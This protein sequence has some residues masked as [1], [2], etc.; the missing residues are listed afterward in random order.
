MQTGCGDEVRL[1]G[2]AGFRG[3]PGWTA[4]RTAP[5]ELLMQE[6]PPLLA[7]LAERVGAPAFQFN[8]Y[9]SDSE[10][11]ME[12]DPSGRVEL[13]GY[14]GYEPARYWNGDP[15]MDRVDAQFHIIDPS[16]VTAWA[17]SAMPNACVTGWLYESE[18]RRPEREFDK[19]F[20]AKR[21]D[22]ARWLGNIGVK[23]RSRHADSRWSDWMVHPAQIIR[24]LALA[25]CAYLPLEDC[26][27]PAI[28]TVFG[29]PNAEHCDNLF[30]VQTLIPHAPLPVDGFALYAEP[31][32][33]AGGS[34]WAAE[35]R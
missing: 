1:W 21:A 35:T 29:G 4:V 30:L 12:A 13:S 20:Q 17:E 32:V 26:V 23:A 5:F 15:P 31:V 28:K 27:E 33:T 10:L 8:I 3:S 25:G 19:L 18:L 11:L 14:V 34:P 9:D 2:I 24:R 16:E 7:R 6:T 22:L